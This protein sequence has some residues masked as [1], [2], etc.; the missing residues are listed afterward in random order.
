[1]KNF[2]KFWLL[3]AVP[4]SCPNGCGQPP[5]FDGCYL[6]V[7]PSSTTSEQC[8][9][10]RNHGQIRWDVEARVTWLG[11]WWWHLTCF[12]GIWG[13]QNPSLFSPFSI[14]KGGS[15]VIIPSSACQL[16]RDGVFENPVAIHWIAALSIKIFSVTSFLR[17]DRYHSGLAKCDGVFENPVM[18]SP[19]C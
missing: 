6:L 2:F 5:G 19:G 15:S 18:I 17:N 11:N 4:E 8:C 12:F 10:Q 13:W 1:M 16:N 3:C 7:A 14:G 9:L